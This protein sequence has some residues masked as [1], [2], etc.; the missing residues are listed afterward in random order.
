MANCIKKKAPFTIN[1]PPVSYHSTTLGFDNRVHQNYKKD[2]LFICSRPY[3][4]PDS[5]KTLDFIYSIVEIFDNNDS[6]LYR[7]IKSETGMNEVVQELNICPFKIDTFSIRSWGFCY[8][9]AKDKDTPFNS[10]K[11]LWGT[12]PLYEKQMPSKIR[13]KKVVA[14][15]KEQD[16]NH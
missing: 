6:L 4:T 3:T 1:K 5:S 2:S 10:K 8:V 13:G 15:E 9:V 16:L 12:T 14:M 7:F 11:L